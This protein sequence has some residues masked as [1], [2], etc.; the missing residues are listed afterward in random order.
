ME[1]YPWDKVKTKNING[2]EMTF[3][4]KFYYRIWNSYGETPNLKGC[5][6]G[7][8]VGFDISL[9]KRPGYSLYPAFE[10]YD[11]GFW[12]STYKVSKDKDGALRSMKG[13][14]PLTN[15]SYDEAISMAKDMGKDCKLPTFLEYNAFMLLGFLKNGGKSSFSKNPFDNDWPTPESTEESKHYSSNDKDKNYQLAIFPEDFPEKISV[16]SE[17]EGLFDSKDF[18]TGP[19][20]WVYDTWRAS[21]L[22]AMWDSESHSIGQAYTAGTNMTPTSFTGKYTHYAYVTSVCAASN[23]CGGIPM[24]YPQE[25]A[26]NCYPTTFVLGSSLGFCGTDKYGDHNTFSKGKVYTYPEQKSSATAWSRIIVGGSLPMAYHIVTS[27]NSAT[28]FFNPKAWTDSPYNISSI[29]GYDDD[30]YSF[31]GFRYVK[32]A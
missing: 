13:N 23:I 19:S 27:T 32:G 18:G 29:R 28:G 7:L 1:L 16:N 15:V 25:P 20:E 12:I 26:L 4:P 5:E 8:S 2:N 21:G 30:K 3:I 11:K 22:A 9:D 17:Y 6:A 24:I 31:I 14:E 10:N